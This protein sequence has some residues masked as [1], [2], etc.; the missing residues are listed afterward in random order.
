M[1]IVRHCGS[2]VSI[3]AGAIFCFSHGS[4]CAQRSTNRDLNIGAM[5]S[6]ML[7]YVDS[8]QMFRIRYPHPDTLPPMSV[9]M[10]Y[11]VLIGYIAADS[12]A[13][14]GV[15]ADLIT[16]VRGWTSMNDTLRQIGKHLYRMVDRDPARYAQYRYD[17]DPWHAGQHADS[18][19]R[20]NHLFGRIDSTHAGYPQKYS[21]RLETM[22]S[23]IT[24]AYVRAWGNASRRSAVGA[25][26]RSSYI[27]RIRTVSVDSTY[28]YLSNSGAKRY[29]VQAVVLDT[30]KGQRFV[31]MCA[32]STNAY[33]WP[34]GA[35]TEGRRGS[36]AQNIECPIIRFGYTPNMYWSGIWQP[37]PEVRFVR[38]T[39]FMTSDGSFR[40]VAGQEMIVFLGFNN[41]LLDDGYDYFDLDVD[42][43][44]SW[45][46]LRIRNGN[47]LDLNDVWGLGIDVPYPVFRAAVRTLID[48]I[49]NP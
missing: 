15:P 30:L 23:E 42:I 32:D 10:P 3:L 41:R 4:I 44:C 34:P 38:D 18:M 6:E 39:A 16:H 45:G 48:R 25:L 21:L 5:W 26:L 33:R 12:G 19:Y 37:N 20:G 49:D 40:L 17:V 8:L 13:R 11:D 47:V 43:S 27:L 2:L 36:M 28:N 46:V 1:S 9:S 14:T 35:L 22:E 29:A 24:K 31:D 7:S